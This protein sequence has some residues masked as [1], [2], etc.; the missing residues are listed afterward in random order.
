MPPCIADSNLSQCSRRGSACIPA[1]LFKIFKKRTKQKAEGQGEYSI[2]TS[3]S[4]ALPPSPPARLP[5]NHAVRNEDADGE[6]AHAPP[7]WECLILG[8]VCVPVS[9]CH[10]AVSLSRPRP[11]VPH[12][13]R[14][15]PQM[16][17]EPFSLRVRH[18][19]S[20]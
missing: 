11:V 5:A 10:V 12:L 18:V 17:M 14:R 19:R 8:D 6:E 3:V 15:P 7:P 1:S 16:A 9:W 13:L 2:H 4:C 20:L